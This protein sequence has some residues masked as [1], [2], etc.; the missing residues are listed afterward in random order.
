M[1]PSTTVQPLACAAGGARFIADRHPQLRQTFLL[2]MSGWGEL[3]AV[4]SEYEMD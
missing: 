3:G 2:D 1:K 4:L